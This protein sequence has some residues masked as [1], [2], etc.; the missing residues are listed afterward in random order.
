MN[1]L[2]HKKQFFI[3]SSSLVVVG[4]LGLALFGLKLGIDF[5]GG[6]LL[7]LKGSGDNATILK[8]AQDNGVPTPTVTSSG[9]NLFLLRYGVTDDVEDVHQQLVSSYEAQGFSEQ[10]FEAIGPS[11]S[12]ELI[13]NA[14]YSIIALS[15]GVVIYISYTFRNMPPPVKPSMYGYA[16]IVALLHDAFIVIGAFAW[17]GRFFN[18]EV[19]SFFVTAVL[20]VIAFSVHDTLVVFD[21][22][23]EKLIQSTD[24]FHKVIDRSVSDVLVRSVNTSLTLILVLFALL[25]FG[26][27]TIQAFV[28]ALLIGAIVGTYSSIFIASPLLVMMYDK[29][30]AREKKLKSSKKKTTKKKKSRSSKKSIKK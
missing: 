15:L 3:I 28:L 9:D 19:D 11:V 2:K 7:E 20:T 21:R 29:L 25:I 16:A 6:S 27:H 14:F 12:S 10:R 13:K 26:G 24:Q 8:I 5:T 17:L 4:A 23:R 18:V 1:I 30:R 22:V